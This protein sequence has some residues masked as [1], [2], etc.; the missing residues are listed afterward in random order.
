MAILLAVEQWRQYLQHAEFV[1]HTDHCSLAHLEDQRLHT[2]WQQKVF[3]KLLGLQFV[4]KY[5][6]GADNRAADALSRRPAPEA[7]LCAISQL[8]PAWLSEVAA[9]YES[10]EF[11]S[12]LLARL[13]LQPTAEDHFT[14]RDGIIR[15]KN[16]IWLPANAALLPKILNS[17]HAS[18]VGGHSGF[19][20][21]LRRVKSLFY[22]KNM[23]ASI[24]QYVQECLICQ[25]AKPD[26][27]R[28]PGLLAPLP[29]PSQFWQM[30]SLDFVDGLPRSGGVNSVLVVVDKLSRY[31]HFIGLSH[32]YTVS[33]VVAAYMD[34]VHKLHGMP[35]SIVSDRDSI[36]TSR[37]WREMAAV[38]GIKLRMSS[39]HHPQTDGTTER[40]NQC[41]EAYL[42]CFTH[43]CPVKWAQWLSL[44][45]FWYN[46]SA[47]LA[48]DGKSPFQVLYG[49][50]PRHFGLSTDDTCAVPDV[51]AWLQQRDLMLRV[52]Q[53]HLERVRA[54]M[55]AQADKKRSDRV[56]QVG[57]SVFMKL[58]PYIQSSVAP[59]A[60]HKLLFKYYGP[61]KILE[62][63]GAS[64]YRLQ[65]PEHSRIHPV[66]HVSQ[67]KR[68]LG[69]HCQVQPDLPP[70][71]AQY[72]VPLRVLQRRFRRQGVASIPQ[73]LIQWSDQPESLATWED[74]EELQQ[75]FPHAPAWGQAAFQGRGIVSSPTANENRWATEDQAV[76]EEEGRRVPRAR[77]AATRYASEEWVT[78]PTKPRPCPT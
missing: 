58:Q 65:L 8:Q 10:D 66:L 3:T 46:T 7:S 2:T 43:A 71:D 68:A 37:F 64:A 14:L 23:K 20:M 21:T 41:L 72:A 74:L 1:I 63:I 22:W 75:R 49:H 78:A 47:H 70:P 44:A 34:N 12:S 29:V 6:K 33:T 69:P 4:I 40:V 48:L 52:L 38:T 73:A 36:F 5:K 57:D 9:L 53:Q 25:R 51:E 27:A 76:T 56:F 32:P 24:R 61:Y 45:E 15:Y 60:H 54:R 16:R 30:V 19:S 18:P 31:A 39:S 77:K 17:L 67:L 26:R 13:A 35:D 59:R 62:R 11:A 50:S 55:K 42:R 28:Y